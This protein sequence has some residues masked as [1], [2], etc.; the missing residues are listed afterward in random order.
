LAVLAFAVGSLTFLAV[1]GRSMTAD[2]HLVMAWS[3]RYFYPQQVLFVLA[4]AIFAVAQIPWRAV[5]VGSRIA[6]LAF[7]LTYASY[8]HIHNTGFFTTSKEQGVATLGFLRV[9]SQELA[10]ARERDAAPESESRR[11]LVF[12]R[13]G[14]WDI[15]IELPDPGQHRS[16]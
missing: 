13:G 3:H 5:S 4:F 16:P 15:V 6:A 2:S 10:A 1:V 12:E 7:W 14:R 9:A 11:Q 8:L